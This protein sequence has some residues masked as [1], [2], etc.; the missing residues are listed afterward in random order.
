MTLHM[1][2]LGQAHVYT[3]PR[4]LVYWEPCNGKYV[5]LNSSQES[6]PLCGSCTL[7]LNQSNRGILQ[8]PIGPCGQMIYLS[9]QGQTWQ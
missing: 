3:T 7:R 5:H 6:L 9:G 2:R 8:I 1:V 4:P